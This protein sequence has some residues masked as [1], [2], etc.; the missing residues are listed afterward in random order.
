LL[1]CNDGG[2]LIIGHTAFS[3]GE[4]CDGYLIKT[5]ANGNEIWRSFIGGNL[6]DVTNKAVELPDGSFLVTGKIQDESR[7]FHALLAK[8]ASNGLILF[9]K[10]IPSEKQEII[11]NIKK[12]SDDNL[13]LVG[14]VF[15]GNIEQNLLLKCDLE[16]NLIW[17]KTWGSAIK[18][19][20]FDVCES[21]NSQYFVVG[22]A[23]DNDRDLPKMNIVLFD[24]DGNFIQEL[25][26]IQ[27]SGIG[28]LTACD[29][30]ENGVLVVA[31]SEQ[32][33]DLQQKP[34]VAWLDKNLN[35]VEKRIIPQL[36]NCRSRHL[37]LQ[38][39][40]VIVVGNTDNA[41]FVAKLVGN[42]AV[43]KANEVDLQSN[44]LFPNPMKERSYLKTG[45][46]FGD[47]TL[48]IISIEGKLLRSEIFST[49]DF[50]IERKNLN[51][52]IYILQIRSLNGFLLKGQKLIV[53]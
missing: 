45:L 24:T 26:D 53:N 20:L 51:S 19:R 28:R 38:N 12:T 25:T 50:F 32:D 5:D 6:D 41:S 44:L 15:D 34:M 49:D 46:G 42:D 40:S 10:Q 48:E 11:F 8:V 23:L 18:Q 2:F 21:K 22:E 37:T 13:L 29:F 31:G 39:E 1:A 14:Y 52:G 30:N 36:G 27:L 9:T 4:A 17:R 35:V 16:G 33:A 3:Y 47:K 7:N 43:L